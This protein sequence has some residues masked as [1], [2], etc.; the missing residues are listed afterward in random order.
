MSNLLPSGFSDL[1]GVNAEKHYDVENKLISLFRRNNFDLYIPSLFDYDN[2][3][4]TD[5]SFKLVDPLDNKILKIRSDITEQAT[6]LFKEK[7]FLLDKF[8]YRG[9]IYIRKSLAGDFNRKYTQIGV[10][11]IRKKQQDIKVI[12]LLVQAISEVGI[13]DFTISLSLPLLFKEYCLAKKLAAAEEL[14]LLNLLK[15]KDLVKL[16]LSKY[17]EISDYA[18]SKSSETI[19]FPLVTPK[20]NKILLDFKKLVIEISSNLSPDQVKIDLFKITHNYHTDFAFEI[21]SNKLKNLI[22]RGGTYNV[23]SKLSAL[24]FSLYVEELTKLV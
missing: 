3:Q 13:N 14:F 11:A 9:D 12:K 5:N 24:G 23:S 18:Y 4:Q 16:K 1:Y 22:A 6:R 19:D 8:C 2:S 21:Y 10:E 20:I 15:N 7:D 17:S